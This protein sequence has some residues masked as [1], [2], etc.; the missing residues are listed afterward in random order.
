LECT[1]YY[2]SS[3]PENNS[4]ED[5][6]LIDN[7]TP[8]YGVYNH[9]ILPTHN[10]NYIRYPVEMRV[11]PSLTI[12]SPSSGANDAFNESSGRDCRLSGGTIGYNNK[13]RLV[14]SG[15]NVIN[16]STSSTG[17]KICILQGIVDYDRVYYHIVADAD[18]PLP[19]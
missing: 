19:S 1:K 15:L 7:K 18:Y 2:Y 3:Y 9:I 12:Y 16:T 5:S 8:D 6:T 14:K 4:P 11:E 10:C 13:N 17:A